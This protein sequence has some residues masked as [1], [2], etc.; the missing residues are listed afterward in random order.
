VAWSPDGSTVYVTLYR[1]RHVA[2]LDS[3]GSLRRALPVGDWPVGAATAATR[4][5]LLT[6]DYASDAVSIVQCPAGRPIAR[7]PVTRMPYFLAVS[8]DEKLAVVGNR[9]PADDASQPANGTAGPTSRYV[10][11]Q[12]SSAADDPTAVELVIGDRP[13]AYGM[14]LYL[15]GI[16][17][18]I[19]LPGKGPRGLAL[20]PDGRRL[21]L[22]MY[23]A[24]T[25]VWIDAQ[26]LTVGKVTPLDSRLSLRERS[27]RKRGQSRM[28][29]PVVRQGVATT[30]HHRG[31][32]R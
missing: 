23:F 27:A 29:L 21:A 32:G 2:E 16:V 18:R 17:R 3:S 7:L 9:L 22:A 1:A 31:E 30:A 24:G 25:V 19:D 13:A 12:G 20:S 15:P 14:G 28:A 6:A 5:W 11:G 4:G 26:T 10:T 8:P